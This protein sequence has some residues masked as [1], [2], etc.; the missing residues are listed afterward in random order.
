MRED[1]E[2][3][4]H[5]RRVKGLDP[6]PRR[7]RRFAGEMV[8]VRATAARRDEPGERT[9]RRAEAHVAHEAVRLLLHLGRVGDGIRPHERAGRISV[10]LR[11]EQR[12]EGLNRTGCRE[13][14]AP[15]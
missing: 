1:P 12:V 9:R 5:L 2:R 7:I 3:E 15:R 10:A 14:P 8:Q 13:K 6:P 4:R 11:A